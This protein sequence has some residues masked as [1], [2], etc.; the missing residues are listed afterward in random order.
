M[1][2]K[3]TPSG[4]RRYVH[5]IEAFRDAS[6]APN[7]RTVAT[8]GRLDQLSTGLN[9]AISGLLRVTGRKMSVTV[10]PGVEFERDYGDDWVQAEL[11]NA[12]GFDRLRPVFRGT[13]H[14]IDV[15]ALAR[16]MV[17]NRLCE[18]ESKLG[19]LRWLQAVSMPALSPV[20]IEH[21]HLLR[22]MDALVTQ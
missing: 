7:Q 12:L 10:Q 14:A 6:G 9:S 17:F 2:I 19:E 16:L 5:L 13:R 4:P 8:L 15:G 22:A 1:F 3:R 18:S 21:Q 20:L 11:W